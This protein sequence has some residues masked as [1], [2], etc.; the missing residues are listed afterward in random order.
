MS[1]INAVGSTCPSVGPSNARFCA[2][3]KLQSA[4][5]PQHLPPE[6]RNIHVATGKC[7]LASEIGDIFRYA[8]G[9][10]LISLEVR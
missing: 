6:T 4:Q 8:I 9:P 1:F 5:Q 3:Q 10:S 7:A 2:N